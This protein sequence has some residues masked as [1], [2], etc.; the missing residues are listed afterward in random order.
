L[1]GDNRPADENAN[2]G[3]GKDKNIQKLAYAIED[4]LYIEAI[5]IKD[6]RFEKAIL[7]SKFAVKFP[8][9]YPA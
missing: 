6:E 2:V 8:I 7:S 5:K 4:L 1:L 9:L 3:S